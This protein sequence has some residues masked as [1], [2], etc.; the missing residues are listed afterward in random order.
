[1]FNPSMAGPTNQDKATQTPFPVANPGAF[2][3]LSRFLHCRRYVWLPFKGTTPTLYFDV[4]GRVLTA[5]ARYEHKSP[6]YWID[7]TGF[8]SGYDWVKDFALQALLAVFST[9]PWRLK[10]EWV[11]FCYTAFQSLIFDLWSSISFPFWLQFVRLGIFF[12]FFRGK[13]FFLLLVP[14]R[15]FHF[16]PSVVGFYRG[17]RERNCRCCGH[18]P[19]EDGFSTMRGAVHYLPTAYHEE[20]RSV[21]KK[22]CFIKVFVLEGLFFLVM[23]NC[24]FYSDADEGPDVQDQKYSV[25]VEVWLE[26]QH[27]LSVTAPRSPAAYL[28]GLKYKQIP[29]KVNNWSI[30]QSINRWNS[31]KGE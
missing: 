28:N 7:F 11:T 31:A 9:W 30:N 16:F 17:K 5:L 27:G 22:T 12:S 2:Q 23:D 26:P 25:A 24:L 10:W 13:R 6:F 15:N 3:A 8:V 1:M 20:Q 18:G 4:I 29:E 14:W 21:E 19:I